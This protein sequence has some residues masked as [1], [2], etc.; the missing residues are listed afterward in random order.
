MNLSLYYNHFIQSV[1]GLQSAQINGTFVAR[2]IE[3]SK[4]NVLLLEQI[5]AVKHQITTLE[6]LAKKETQVAEMV[7]YNTKIQEH[8]KQITE[9]TNKIVNQ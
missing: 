3:Q 7:K 9:L 5:E 4:E 1:I 6:N 2:P 8:R